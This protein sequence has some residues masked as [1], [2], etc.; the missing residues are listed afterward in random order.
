MDHLP[1]FLNLQ[2]R[3]CLIVGGGAVALRKAE[4][5]RQAGAQITLLA[6][7][8]HPQLLSW[9][10]A[11]TI[12]RWLPYAAKDFADLLN[13]RINT[14]VL[15][16]AATDDAVINQTVHD[17]AQAANIPV[18]VV[19]QPALCSFI[20]PSIIDRSPVIIAASTGGRA[21]VLARLLREK[22]EGLI[23]QHY[24]KLAT[25]AGALRAQ[26]KQALPDIT[27]RRRFWEQLLRSPYADQLMQT[28]SVDAKHIAENL[29]THY[30]GE[31]HQH[32][33][34]KMGG[35]VYLVGAGPGDPELLTFRA[36]R[37][38]QQA[39]VVLYDK[40][41]SDEVLNLV[42]RDAEKIFVGKTQG[43]HSKPQ[44]EINRLLV[45]YAQQG[46][47][48]CRLK[49][50]DPFIFGRGG[51]ELQSLVAAKVRF[52]VVPGITAATACAAYAG[53]PLTHRDHA[54]SL[55]FVTGHLR[56][57]GEFIL[58]GSLDWQTLSKP[59]QTVVFYM[60]LKNLAQITEQLRA[61]GM[62]DVMPIAI[63]E[64]GTRVNQ[65]V[66]SGTLAN[67]VQQT[68]NND[69]SQPSLIIIGEVAALHESLQWFV[70]ELIENSV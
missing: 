2:Q 32:T 65:R 9:H 1:I 40:L 64:N 22:L 60:G 53:I 35:E 58:N 55:I 27:V 16:I 69:A 12:E 56:E 25:L 50:G 57:D 49:G 15:V 28:N 20:F 45:E 61:H 70:P 30:T 29:L 68:E 24:G 37:L 21:P 41:V 14:F 67:I 4:L 33:A 11:G 62:P 19:D 48:V 47:R 7:E 6:T 3:R 59:Q 26:I 51:E 38:M 43:C 36:L 17:V 31:N 66:I 13:E 44:S 18:N 23:P 63:V 54:Q 34:N 5:L 10:E 52:Q 42:R 46:K 8:L 39:D